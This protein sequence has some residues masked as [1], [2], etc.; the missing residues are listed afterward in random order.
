M[1]FE[2]DKF[3]GIIISQDDFP[4]DIDM[5]TAELENIVTFSQVEKKNIIWLTLPIHLSHF[6][7]AAT[8]S[9]F[10]FH[11]CLE[12]ELTLIHKA[13][14]TTFIPFI[15]TH[16]IGAGAIVKNE[17]GELLVIREHGMKGFKLPGGHVELG[18]KIETAIIREVAE[19][20]G[21]A[22]A[23]HAIVGF[24]T[25]HPFQFGKTNLYF[26]CRLHAISD[27]ISIQDMEEVAEAKWISVDEYLLDETNASFN[28]Q[29]VE[30]CHDA[31]GLQS[32]LPSNNAGPYKKHETFF[33]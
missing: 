15:P 8:K 13:P 12:Q 31:K 22:A 32:F 11:N 4:H 33:A 7:S 28:R 17:A 9:G 30:A 21:V 10:V 3:N 2:L 18:E 26:V 5:F 19:E 27:E 16:T 25:R 29:M 1:K 23:F 6:V 24:T 20:T 14:E